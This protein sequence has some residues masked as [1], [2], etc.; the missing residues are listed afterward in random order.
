MLLFTGGLAYAPASSFAVGS[1]TE[2]GPA[3][4]VNGST[5]YTEPASGR[6]T[7]IAADPNDPLTIYIATA[8]GG[9]WKTI[10]G[11]TSWTPL[12]DTQGTLFMGAIAVAPSDSNTIYAVTGEANS[13]PSKTKREFRDNIYYGLGVL[14]STN[15]GNTWTLVGAGQFSRRTISRIV[16]DPT[17]PDTVYVAVGALATNGLPGNTGI[18]KSTDGGTTWSNTTASISTTAAFSDLVMDPS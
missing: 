18:W 1:W 11:G 17:S 15:G 5:T 8:G 9:V 16:V 4:T 13:G 2:L 14:R 12:T 10:D 6:I 3:P 7:G